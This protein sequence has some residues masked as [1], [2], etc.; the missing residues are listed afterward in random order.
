[1]I[2]LVFFGKSTLLLGLIGELE[3]YMGKI[4]VKGRI[5]YVSQQPWIFTASIKQNIIFGLEFNRQKFDQV[6]EVCSL[7]KVKSKTKFIKKKKLLDFFKK[8]LKLLA[9]GENTLV[10]EKGINLSGGQRA[11][12]SM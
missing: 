6:V 2:I 9:Y 1:M 4:D 8:D 5:A 11:R 7:K 10:G 3:N 12:I